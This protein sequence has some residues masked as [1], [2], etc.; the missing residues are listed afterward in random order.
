MIALEQ[1]AEREVLMSRLRDVWNN[2]DLDCCASLHAFASA[3]AIFETLPEATI[4]LSVMKQPL[5]EAK[6]FTH[7]D[8]TLGSL[9][10]CLALFET[11]SIDIQPDDLKEVMAMSAG[12]SL[13]M[14]EYIFNDPRDDPGIP[15]RRTIGSIGKPGVSFLLSAQ[16]LDSLSPDY[17]T[18]K[19]V[20]YAPFDGSIENNFDHTTLHLT[21]TGDEQPLN[22]GQTGYHDKEVF[23]LEAVVRAYDKSR[24]VADLDLNLRPNPLVHKL[25]ATGECAHDEHERDDYAA[26][27]PLTSIDSWDELLD[28]PPNTGIVR[29]RAN[30]LARQAVAAFALQ[31]SIPLI[32]ASESICWR[33]VAQ[34]MNFG[35]VLDGPNWLIIC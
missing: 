28:P 35:L 9:F 22:I 17:S 5:S 10:S 24:W 23:L 34:V 15:V 26:F 30:W 13:F 25:L 6:W 21:L 20:Q 18:W 1:Q 11:G 33:C 29:A 3:A 8:P 32:V 7:R 14:A 4:S 12:N 19:S 16:G 31:Q 27:Q 2:G